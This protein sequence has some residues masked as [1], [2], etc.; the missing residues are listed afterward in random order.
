MPD[1]NLK[2]TVGDIVPVP[3]EQAQDA[4]DSGFSQPTQ[5]DL[6]AAANE[7]K[8]GGAAGEAKAALA[9]AGR[10]ATFGLS[11]QA[12]TK[13]G[14][15]SPETL[16][17]LKE[18]NPGASTAGELA[19]VGA[20]LLVPGLGEE[21][22]AGEALRA[23]DV[24]NPVKA[25]SHVGTAIAEHVAPEASGIAQRALGL[26]LGSAAE[27]SVYGLG[28]SISDQAL[29]D[30]DAMGEKL[31]HNVGFGALIGLGAGVGV[32]ALGGTYS[33]L[34]GKEAEEIG[35]SLAGDAPSTNTENITSKFA[36][37]DAP[38]V[39]AEGTPLET[40]IQQA[41][42]A[43][44]E[45]LRSGVLNLRPDAAKTEA[46]AKEFGF[47]AQ[48][49]M[50]SS[51]KGI[52]LKEGTLY[53]SPS[54]LG[55]EV[56][57]QYDSGYKAMNTGVQ[58][59]LE[60]QG[61]ISD[62]IAA[63]QNIREGMVSEIQK[64]AGPIQDLYNMMEPELR[65]IDVPEATR[66][67]LKDN[68]LKYI[69]EGSLTPTQERWVKE[70]ADGM[71]KISNLD[72]LK[73]FRTSINQEANS[74]A[75]KPILS[76]IAGD[77]SEM[78]DGVDHKQISKFAQSMPEGSA[79]D[80][81]MTLIGDI[82][83]ARAQYSG[84]KDSFKAIS[85]A[86]FGTDKVG[87]PQ[88]FIRKMEEHLTD[89]KFMNKL[90]DKKN[91][92]AFQTLQEIFPEQA[93]QIKQLEKS[94]IVA[95]ARAH[96]D[97]NAL[98]ATK[99]ILGDGRSGGMSKQLQNQLFT[100]EELNKLDLAQHGIR[101][102]QEVRHFNPSNSGTMITHSE[103]FQS[104]LDSLKDGNITGAIG[105]ALAAPMQQVKDLMSYSKLQ[106]SVGKEGAAKV[107]VL[108][109]LEKQAQ[110]T[111]EKIKDYS[112][113]IFDFGK[114]YPLGAVAKVLIPEDNDHQKTSEAIQGYSNNPQKLIDDLDQNT[115]SLYAF[116]PNVTGGLQ[117]STANAVKFLSMKAPVAP[118]T[119]PLGPKLSPSSTQKVRFQNYY[120]GVKNPLHAMEKIQEGTLLPD[121]IETLNA[122]YPKMY[123]EMQQSITSAMVDH[124]DKNGT[125][126]IPNQTKM[127]LSLFLGQDMDSSM[128]PQAVY[129]NQMV[130]GAARQQSQ[131]QDQQS[132]RPSQ[133]G[134]S[135]L[136]KSS[137]MLTNQQE[138]S[139]RGAES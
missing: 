6:A 64:N 92:K 54:K 128:S 126:E 86:L 24:L 137:S 74:L 30:P 99:E 5:Q 135:A 83:N 3:Q 68:L 116:A 98:T 51:D 71:G 43:D 47:E 20:S 12:L 4:L 22:A 102:M 18:A 49:A 109:S 105:N 33:K 37:D 94:R 127:M 2:N 15:V 81:A 10:G 115:K 59:V 11:D 123:Q 58:D 46:A 131:A 32:G 114:R 25:V 62:P 63:A 110:K 23:A 42:K 122:V 73:S 90:F 56:R 121:D 26:G 91:H 117:R 17:G 85:K 138:I 77:I 29:G 39:G 72:K 28:Q 60:G 82:K 65:N 1:V 16:K 96:G 70:I 79:R 36:T 133:K 100:P 107:S 108:S 27:G 124:V 88:G 67:Q 87:G 78:F 52:E 89:E 61:V 55:E 66:A 106:Q 14:L 132:V 93:E 134:L 50:L 41:P 38:V 84:L 112:Q 31:L 130:L 95:K 21:N 75:N 9:G 136:N 45:S 69:N 129:A 34:F 97:F 139:Q 119:G 7:A 125:S 103:G 35:T 40:D 118:S 113:N 8:Y 53:K 80:T 101:R 104:I 76:H 120:Q 13:T 44:Q 48:P 19:G 57:Q 111:T